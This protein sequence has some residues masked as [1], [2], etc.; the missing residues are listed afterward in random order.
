[1]LLMARHIGDEEFEYISKLTA[2]TDV[3]ITLLYIVADTGYETQLEAMCNDK[4]SIVKYLSGIAEFVSNPVEFEAIRVS[5]AKSTRECHGKV[6]V[7]RPVDVTIKHG[8]IGIN[9]LIDGKRDGSILHPWLGD[10]EH[11]EYA[12]VEQELR[13]MIMRKS[14]EASNQILKQEASRIYRDLVCP[15]APML[16]IGG[17]TNQHLANLDVVKDTMGSISVAMKHGVVVD[18]LAA[19]ASVGKMPIAAAADELRDIVKD[20][21]KADFEVVQS[22]KAF[23]ELFR[24]MREVLPMLLNVN[25]VIVPNSIV[26]GEK[27]CQY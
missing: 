8:L 13:S 26:R 2:D 17:L 14:H 4:F 23:K 25:T 19:M 27:Q 18:H 3:H 24:R 15:Y 10:E 12:K 1:M 16:I 7:I 20:G 9:G 5:T 6:T 11:V 22:A 21:N